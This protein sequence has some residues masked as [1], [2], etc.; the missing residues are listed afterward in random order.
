V[1]EVRNSEPTAFGLFGAGGFGREVIPMV[2]GCL[3]AEDQKDNFGKPFFVTRDGQ[4]DSLN[5]YDV[6]SEANFFD[7]PKTCF[8]VAISESKLRERIVGI[9]LSHGVKPLS[10]IHKNVIFFDQNFLGE[11]AIICAFSTITSDIRI[12]DYFHSNIYSYI[13]HDCIVGDFVT[14]AP[15]VSCNGH[16]HIQNHAY[17]GTGAVIR[18]GSAQNPLTIGEGAIVGMGA[19]VT[20]DVEAHTTVIGNPARFLRRNEK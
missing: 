14:F 5:G 16:V 2:P 1:S 10:I 15:R 9:C 7:L 17:I 4:D 6:I 12:G 18:E 11:G 19:V 3:G 8:N 13:G 20:K